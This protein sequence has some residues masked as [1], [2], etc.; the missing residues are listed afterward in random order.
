MIVAANLTEEEIK[1]FKARKE[2][3]L[4]PGSCVDVYWCQGRMVVRAYF[5]KRGP[6]PGTKYRSSSEQQ[7]HGKATSTAGGVAIK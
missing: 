1:A 6:K 7:Q 5:G 2:Q 3:E 4:G